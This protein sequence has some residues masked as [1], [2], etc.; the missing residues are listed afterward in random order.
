MG[1]FQSI[2]SRIERRRANRLS[3][4]FTNKACL[5]PIDT[6]SP[7]TNSQVNSLPASPRTTTWEDPWNDFPASASVDGRF[8]QSLPSTRTQGRP[9]IPREFWSAQS[10]SIAEENHQ[11]GGSY[12][13]PSSIPTTPVIRRPSSLQKFRRAS[14]HP[15]TTL[16]GPSLSSPSPRQHLRS[17]SL[18]STPQSP[19]DTIY[20]NEFEDATSSNTYFMVDSQRFSITRRRS[21]LTRPGMATRRTSK[22]SVRRVSPPTAGG[23]Y[24]RSSNRT[25][26]KSRSM[27][28]PLPDS[29]G[30][31]NVKHS[32]SAAFSRPDTPSDFQ[33][34]H[35]GALKLGS[36]RVVNRS[37]SPCPS[38]QSN[39]PRKSSE[40]PHPTR[41]AS[42]DH[43]E[44]SMSREPAL[45]C[46]PDQIIGDKVPLKATPGSTSGELSK[47]LPKLS[48]M[49]DNGEQADDPISPFSFQK[50]PTVTTLPP[51]A[52]LSAQNVEKANEENSAESNGPG[53]RKTT[54][55]LSKTDSG[56]SSATSTH[57]SRKF[58]RASIDS[59]WL[60]RHSW[61]SCKMNSSE[62][63]RQDVQ[64]FSWTSTQVPP[65]RHLSLQDSKS[66][67]YTPSLDNYSRRWSGAG[68]SRSFSLKAP[69][70]LRRSASSVRP[71]VPWNE[72]DADAPNNDL[73][74]SRPSVNSFDIRPSSLKVLHHKSVSAPN[75]G[76]PRLSFAMGTPSPQN[77]RRL[78]AGA[79]CYDSFPYRHLQR[80][81]NRR[82]VAEA[83]T[84][85]HIGIDMSTEKFLLSKDELSIATWLE[86]PSVQG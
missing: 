44:D 23:H 85:Q 35:L 14:Y 83:K 80:Q 13:L 34:T 53:E 11:Y 54:K 72:L 50:S 3:K 38:D 59:Q 28:L 55:S 67:R 69:V 51:Y 73:R 19:D 49:S 21:L 37:A 31:D 22:Q 74:I 75:P 30:Y 46:P 40:D 5:S 62:H 61:E 76:E 7:P 6:R 29:E 58:A 12:D 68:P 33:Y 17:Y 24:V 60:D 20:E 47:S 63:E 16:H 1:N 48:P 65:Q 15:D 45:P 64:G 36:L 42:S 9:P 25:F 78:D 70:G 86:R 26:E 27:Q 71:C 39:M 8:S 56:Y 84:R 4:S 43:P 10:D 79:P 57:S 82:S 41:L 52:S 66:S 81:N 32:R 18:Q 77:Q 2:P